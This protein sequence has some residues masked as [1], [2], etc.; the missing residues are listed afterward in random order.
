MNI[1]NKSISELEKMF[2]HDANVIAALR[3]ITE[4]INEKGEFDSH[5]VKVANHYRIGLA[6]VEEENLPSSFKGL[7]DCGIALLAHALDLG[8][9]SGFTGEEIEQTR[10]HIQN[11]INW[12]GFTNQFDA[13]KLILKIP[14]VADAKTIEQPLAEILEMN[15]RFVSHQKEQERA[16]I[17][18]RLLALWVDHEELT[19]AIEGLKI[20]A[21]KFRFSDERTFRDA[22]DAAIT[23]HQQNITDLLVKRDECRVAGDFL[24]VAAIETDLAAMTEA[25]AEKIAQRDAGSPVNLKAAAAIEEMD[26]LS[27]QKRELDAAI[28][29]AQSLLGE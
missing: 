28:A 2:A 5:N 14:T 17:Q 19:N 6:S 3:G 20:V 7:I 4:T 1:R 9:K 26:K 10:A 29:K 24:A 16:I 13:T 11:Q 22:M 12:A 21:S 15:E 18:Q 8:E 23:S 27:E 25:V